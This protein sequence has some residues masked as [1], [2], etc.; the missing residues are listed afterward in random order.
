MVVRSSGNALSHRS[1]FHSFANSHDLVALICTDCQKQVDDA[2]DL[3]TANNNSAIHGFFF[4]SR[5]KLT[6]DING[7]KLIKVPREARWQEATAGANDHVKMGRVYMAKNM[8]RDESRYVGRRS[9]RI[10]NA[11]DQ[12]AFIAQIPIAPS[13]APPLVSARAA[14]S[15]VRPNRAA[16]DLWRPITFDGPEHSQPCRSGHKAMLQPEH[17]H[18][19]QHELRSIEE[20]TSTVTPN[21]RQ[22]RATTVAQA[23]SKKTL[24]RKLLSKKTVSEPAASSMPTAKAKS[25]WSIRR[26]QEKERKERAP[27]HH[28]D[29]FTKDG[30]LRKTMHTFSVEDE[31]PSRQWDGNSG[32]LGKLNAMY[33]RLNALG[34]DAEPNENSPLP[35]RPLIIADDAGN[36][37]GNSSDGGNRGDL[38]ETARNQ[39]AKNTNTSNKAISGFKEVAAVSPQRRSFALPAKTKPSD[40]QACSDGST[41]AAQALLDNDTSKPSNISSHNNTSR[42]NKK[43]V[44]KRISNSK[45]VRPSLILKV[46]LPQQARRLEEEKVYKANPPLQ[47]VTTGNG[48]SDPQD[49]LVSSEPLTPLENPGPLKR[50]HDSGYASFSSDFDHQ[51][52]N[53][54]RPRTTLD[55]STPT[56][57][58]HEA[59]D[60]VSTSKNKPKEGFWDVVRD[61]KGQKD[62]NMAHSSTIPKTV[63]PHEREVLQIY[64]AQT[65]TPEL[66]RMRSSRMIQPSPETLAVERS[67]RVPHNTPTI[68]SLQPAAQ[69]L[70]AS[71]DSRTQSTQQSTHGPHMHWQQPPFR[72]YQ[73]GAQT[74]R[75]AQAVYTPHSSLAPVQYGYYPQQL[76]PAPPNTPTQYGSAYG[77]DQTPMY[78]LQSH[79]AYYPYDHMYGDYGAYAQTYNPQSSY[80]L[81]ANSGGSYNYTPSSYDYYS[82]PGN[83]QVAQPQVYNHL[84]DSFYGNWTTPINNHTV[85]T[86]TSATVS[87]RP[88]SATQS[89]ASSYDAS[90]MGR[91]IGGNFRARVEATS[92]SRLPSGTSLD[93]MRINEIESSS[94]QSSQHSQNSMQAQNA[95]SINNHS[96]RHMYGQGLS[97]SGITTTAEHTACG[98]QEQTLAYQDTDGDTELEDNGEDKNEGESSE[99]DSE[100]DLGPFPDYGDEIVLNAAEIAFDRAFQPR[101]AELARHPAEAHVPQA[102]MQAGTHDA[103]EG[104]RW[105]QLQRAADNARAGSGRGDGGHQQVAGAYV[106]AS[107]DKSS[108]MGNRAY[109]T[110]LVMPTV[111]HQMTFNA[112]GQAAPRWNGTELGGAAA[113][114]MDFNEPYS[115]PQVE[116]ATTSEYRQT[117]TALA[118]QHGHGAVNAVHNPAFTN[119][120]MQHVLSVGAQCTVHDNS[121]ASGV[122]VA[123]AETKQ[124]GAA[125]AGAGPAASHA[126]SSKPPRTKLYRNIKSLDSSSSAESSESDADS[127][128]DYKE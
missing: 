114:G 72:P 40:E 80:S 45:I 14:P 23:G 71:L 28:L 9:K 47:T 49:A 107:V 19:L 51:L 37:F 3:V 29:L 7:N 122:G 33:Y 109:S 50:Q 112:R 106:H 102:N 83:N 104:S 52:H 25:I 4:I 99:E 93:Y 124:A 64:S 62:V 57:A 24:S 82:H 54:K 89:Y 126:K 15:T 1:K 127:S 31:L 27:P 43:L 67:M 63:A 95:G 68:Q 66:T 92:C 44:H 59:E 2:N 76:G 42:A 121:V 98:T 8:T 78:S 75:P 39:F 110:G 117:M 69:M 101:Q 123:Q 90:P 125:Q 56:N 100:G 38:K 5:L 77:R 85:A 103:P 20:S 36:E 12:P 113:N 87:R 46:R 17:N 6:H 55:A 111:G 41:P 108:Q 65:H 35:P 73:S 22:L 88:E 86:E 115:Y 58:S 10:A 84:Q 97:N 105:A 81:D 18:D 91:N 32:R 53:I 16:S 128:G 74:Q 34:N 11:T 26:D 118:Y 60:V 116:D 94:N 13:P 79:D 30:E 120:H 119:A 70:Q 48:S 96:R 21:Q 61:F